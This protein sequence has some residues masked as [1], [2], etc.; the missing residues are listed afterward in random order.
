MTPPDE[1]REVFVDAWRQARDAF[2]DPAMGGVDWGRLYRKYERELPRLGCQSELH[3]LIRRLYSELQAL[4]V[5]VYPHGEAQPARPSV[6]GPPAPPCFSDS[7]S[8][9]GGLMRRP[10]DGPGGGVVVAALF[11][12]DVERQQRPPLAKPHFGDA[13][14]IGDRIVGINGRAVDGLHD[15]GAALLGQAGMQVRLRVWSPAARGKAG[16]G[17][18]ES[19][20]PLSAITAPPAV[21]VAIPL[22]PPPGGALPPLRASGGSGGSGGGGGGGSVGGV[23]GVGGALVVASPLPSSTTLIAAVTALTSG[24]GGAGGSGGGGGVAGHASAILAL[25]PLTGLLSASGLTAAS[26]PPASPPTSPGT[27]AAV[28]AARPAASAE[29]ADLSA[30]SLFARASS[31]AAEPATVDGEVRRRAGLVARSDRASFGAHS[32]ALAAPVGWVARDVVVVPLGAHGY[33]RLRYESWLHRTQLAVEGASGGSIGYV[34]LRTMERERGYADFA[35]QVR[36][37]ASLRSSIDPSHDPSH[38]PAHD[39]THHDP[40]PFPRPPCHA[41]LPRAVLPAAPLRR[42]HRRRAA[43]PRRQRGR[44]AVGA[45]QPARVGLLP[46]SRGERLLGGT[47]RP[48]QRLPHG[49][50]LRPADAEQRR[51]LRRRLPPHGARSA[52][53][54]AHVGGGIW[55]SFGHGLQDG[56]AVGVPEIGVYAPAGRGGGA[57]GLYAP[58]GLP[59]HSGETGGATS[60]TAGGAAGGDGAA[61]GVADGTEWIVEGRGVEPDVL[62]DN[63][64]AETFYGSDAQLDAAVRMLLER[65]EAEPPTRPSPPPYPSR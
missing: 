12:G 46:A 43:Q 31:S 4:H 11:S 27:A 33:A 45:A 44:V 29:P 13:V 49:V 16:G 56:S 17:G 62:V 52:R 60:G 25:S 7:P 9:L 34:S 19:A 22:L 6:G 42:A 24:G 39:R 59:A 48:A 57:E 30:A 38:G 51:V 58:G 15:L 54:D 41:P 2:W 65:I 36:G 18:G 3:D 21:S 63:R 10:T 20:L 47:L 55:I 14:A 61:A 37:F 35:E 26:P 53:W 40:T 23:G 1:W 28:G 50:P 8:F 32:G 64:P 5:Y